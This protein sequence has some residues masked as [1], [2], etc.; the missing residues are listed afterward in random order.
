MEVSKNLP[1]IASS[2]AASPSAYFQAGAVEGETVPGC[3]HQKLETAKMVVEDRAGMP[4]E[5]VLV[6]QAVRQQRIA[7]PIRT[8]VS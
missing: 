1:N 4:Q 5:A 8:L 2:S 7:P 6:M 3:T